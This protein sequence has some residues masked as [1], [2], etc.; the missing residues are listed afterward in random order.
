MVEELTP[1]ER[2]SRAIIALHGSVDP[3]KQTGN[4]QPFFARLLMEMKFAKMPK[5]CPMQ[6]MGV[7]AKGNCFYA[8][9]FVQSLT[10]DEV[11]GVLCHE[12]LHCALLHHSRRGSRNKDVANIAQDIV[13]NMMVRKANLVLPKGCVNVDTGYDR[14]D[15]N[16]EGVQM[17]LEKVSA[18][19]WEDIYNEIMQNLKKAG[20]QPQEGKTR[21]KQMG[22]D[23]HFDGDGETG[24]EMSPEETEAAERK[25]QKALVDAAT[26]AKQ[27]GKMPNGLQR[28]IVELLQPRLPWKSLLLKYLRPHLSPVDWSYHKPHRKS[29]LLE[30]FMPVT[31]KESVEVEVVVDTSGSIGKETLTE[32]LS[33]IVGIATAMQHVTMWVT[34]VDAEVHTRYKVD[35]GDIPKILAMEAKG[36][37]GTQMEVGLDHIKKNNPQVPVVVVLTD[38]YDSYN[39]RRQDYPF[40]VIW[41]IQKDGNDKQPY[42]TIIRMG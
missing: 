31:L 42:G 13:V 9:E 17:R 12:I 30:V 6:T 16:L 33:E 7:D 4:E 24:E 32:F 37:G 23:V 21:T 39:R 15:L 40:E 1:E 11:R 19:L 18:R 22:F 27:Q 26:Y 10:K 5:E 8:D 36:G 14:C 25:W 38:G 2:I 35:N 41:C 29:Q 20:K 3:K 34:F 28:I